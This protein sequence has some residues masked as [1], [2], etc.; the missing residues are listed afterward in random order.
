[1]LLTIRTFICFYLI[2]G[3]PTKFV[4]LVFNDVKDIRIKEH[5]L[6]IAHVSLGLLFD[7][8]AAFNRSP[9]FL[10]TSFVGGDFLSVFLRGRYLE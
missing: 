10:S 7:A 1:M 5:I 3:M 9:K 2:I 4:E 6:K 8:S